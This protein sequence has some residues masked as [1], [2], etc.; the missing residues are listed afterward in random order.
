[1][2]LAATLATLALSFNAGAAEFNAPWNDA[3]IALVI[4]PYAANS[5]KWDALAGEPRVVAIIHKATI[6]TQGLDK[7]YWARKAEA[8]QRGYLKP[9]KSA[10]LEAAIPAH[11]RDPEGHW[12]GFTMRARVFAYDKNKVKPEERMLPAWSVL[13]G[14]VKV[15]LPP[16][17]KPVV[18]SPADIVASLDHQGHAGPILAV[19]RRGN[20]RVSRASRHLHVEET[21]R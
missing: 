20:S 15:P 2:K 7:A 19:S 17:G 6:G 14:K 9:V 5:L 8:R 13:D 16:V 3:Q 18:K 21:R 10:I 11:L 1:M 4:D 12:F